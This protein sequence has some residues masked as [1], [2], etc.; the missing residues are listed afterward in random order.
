MIKKLA[1]EVG[2]EPQYEQALIAS[3]KKFGIEVLEVASVPFTHEFRGVNREQSEDPSYW[4]HG[5]IG[6]AKSATKI[7]SWQVHAPWD[8]LKCKYYYERLEGRLLNDE[9]I[10][11]TISGMRDNFV[12]LYSSDLVEDETLFF[13]PNACDKIFSGG[14]ISKNEFDIK[15]DLVR[16]YDPPL[17]TEVIVSRPKKI[18]A[19]ARFFI[20]DSRVVTGSY[21]KTGSQSVWL[22]ADESLI[23]QAEEILDFCLS[24]GYNPDRTWILDLAQHDGEWFILEVGST[25]CSG[26]YKCNTDKII[27]SLLELV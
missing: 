7:T 22:E 21:Y 8:E 11:T 4:F 6:G 2:I 23:A 3:A 27:K 16:F 15:Y 13:R 17:A 9:Y 20:C 24:N 5:C 18:T 1:I 14:C 25:S 12:S 10:E 19:E 26:L